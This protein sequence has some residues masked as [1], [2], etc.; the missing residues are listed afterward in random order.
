[1]GDL[2][3][4]RVNK[5]TPCKAIRTDLMG[6]LIIKCGRSS[7]KRYIC[8]FN[9]LASR[10]VHFEVVQSLETSAFIQGFTR[11]CNRRNVR[12]TDVYSDNGG[13]FVAADKELREG[14][15]NLKNKQFCHSSLKQGTT[16]HFNPPRCSHQEG[17]YE[18]F[19]RLVRK[20]VLSIVGEATLDEYDLLTLVTEI[21]RILTDRPIS[22]LP[23]SPDDLSAITPS[24]IISGS[25][26]D[27]IPPDV[28]MRSDGYKRS[29]RKTQ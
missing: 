17:F 19:F 12:P 5:T 7:V 26:G 6:P 4:D 9:C 22:A 11:F 16:W 15:K 18:A 24:M 14:L 13:N 3:F 21:E 10:T 29:W 28:F 25:I 20:L 8:I 1:M 27:S 2:P 23:S